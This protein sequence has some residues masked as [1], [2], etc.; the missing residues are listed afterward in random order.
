M[1][2]R[3]KTERKREREWAKGELHVVTKPKWRGDHGAKM[4]TWNSSLS[5]TSMVMR[6]GDLSPIKL[7][8]YLIL[9]CSI[10]FSLISWFWFFVSVFLCMQWRIIK[11]WK[12]LSSSM[13]QLPQTWSKTWQFHLRG[14][15]N[16]HSTP[17]ELWKQV[18]VIILLIP[19]CSSL[20]LTLTISFLHF[21]WI[22]VV[23]D[24]F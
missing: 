23:K 21:F 9:S 19:L 18:C 6:T 11:V 24:C 14:R 7:V 4:K 13:D 8:M 20:F 16:H 22:Q 17:P 15:R 10:T 2:E 12:E 3:E 1:C 5:F